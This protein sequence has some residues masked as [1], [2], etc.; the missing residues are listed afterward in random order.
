MIVAVLDALLRTELG[1]GTSVLATLLVAVAFNPV[2]VWLQRKVERMIY[3]ARR[4]PAVAMA[5]VGARLGR[6]AARTSAGLPGVC[7]R[8]PP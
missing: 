7:R 1:L 6:W 2:R 5:A 4:D 8:W 3:G